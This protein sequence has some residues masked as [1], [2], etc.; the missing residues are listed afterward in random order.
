MLAHMGEPAKK[1]SIRLYSEIRQL[2]AEAFVGPSR[3]L[4]S[5]MRYASNMNAS[6]TIIIGDDELSSGTY[7]VR[8]LTSGDQSEMTADGILNF[9]KDYDNS[10]RVN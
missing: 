7:T 3:G 1:E 5:Q 10:H 8:D 6:H 4:K 2:G 9:V